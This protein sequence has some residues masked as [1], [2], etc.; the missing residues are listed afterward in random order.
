MK[1]NILM[2]PI[3]NGPKY[4]GPFVVESKPGDRLTN[5]WEVITA[6]LLDGV[7][8]AVYNRDIASILINNIDIEFQW[9]QETRILLANYENVS[10]IEFIQAIKQNTTQIDPQGD[11]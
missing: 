2:I 1:Q 7:K 6:P 10:F 4:T 11:Y 5:D 9:N 3:E 8:L